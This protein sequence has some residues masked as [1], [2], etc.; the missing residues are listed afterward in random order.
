MDHRHKRCESTTAYAIRPALKETTDKVANSSGRSNASVQKM[1]SHRRIASQRQSLD[2][3]N[4]IAVCSHKLTSNVGHKKALFIRASSYMK[5]GMHKEAIEDCNNLMLVDPENAGA[6]YIRGCAYE[7]LGLIDNSINDFTKALEIDP[8]H[9][10][11]AYARGACENIKVQFYKESFR[12]TLHRR[13]TFIILR[14]R[15][16]G[17]RF[18]R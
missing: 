4:L 6:Y 12:E 14:S 9:V 2:L 16:T 3:D 1:A 5:K 10:N 18:R 11:A 15:R 8:N 13:S 17:Q 7:K